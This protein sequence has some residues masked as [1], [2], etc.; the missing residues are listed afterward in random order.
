MGA[1]LAV[2]GDLDHDGL[3]DLLTGNALDA[4]ADGSV[5]TFIS[6]G[7]AKWV[8]GGTPLGSTPSDSTG[9]NGNSTAQGMFFPYSYGKYCNDGV[10][11]PDAVG[12]S[13]I[14]DYSFL[15]AGTDADCATRCAEDATCNYYTAGL[16]DTC[17]TYRSC[18]KESASTDATAITFR[19]GTTAAPGSAEFISPP[20]HY[21]SI[22]LFYHMYGAGTGKLSVSFRSVASPVV[23]G[24]VAAVV[25]TTEFTLDGN[26]LSQLGVYVGRILQIGSEWRTI[27]GYTTAKVATVSECIGPCFFYLE[28][29]E[30]WSVTGEQH[31]AGDT[32]WTQIALS[33]QGYPRPLE[34]RIEATLGSSTL[35]DIA[36]DRISLLSFN[37][38]WSTD[39][40]RTRTTAVQ[41][42]PSNRLYKGYHVT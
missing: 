17:W 39:T 14:G 15:F 24:T 25:S 29:F 13:G 11:F 35:S 20:G 23:S 10:L 3:A 34:V 16:S 21:K 8:A 2:L 9:P 41:V 37:S 12:S 6:G 31:A 4:S 38:P 30:L 7:F 5:T 22:S 18:E 26:A 32:P 36:V 40:G 27:T 33:L 28:W 1:G 19:K 42:V